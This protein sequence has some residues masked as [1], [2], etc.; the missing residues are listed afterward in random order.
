MTGAIMLR[1]I[2]HLDMGEF[3]KARADLDRVVSKDPYNKE[4]HYKLSQALLRLN[5]PQ[6]AQQH[7]DVS[8]RL[9]AAATEALN[10]VTRADGK[11]IDKQR[12][13]RLAEL[14][15]QLGKRELAEHWRGGS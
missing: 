8:N 4:A 13:Q 10:L 6:E 14:Y 12:R 7:L 11:P 3:E 15:E 9:T 2:L 1:G 5:K